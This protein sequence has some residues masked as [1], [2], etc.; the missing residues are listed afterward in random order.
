MQYWDEIHG[1][2]GMGMRVYVEKMWISFSQTVVCGRLQ[3]TKQNKK[4][5]DSSYLYTLLWDV[6]FLLLLSRG[7]LY[8]S[9]SFIWAGFVN[10]FNLQNT[11]EV[12]SMIFWHRLCSFHS[13][14]LGMLP[15]GCQGKEAQRSLFEDEPYVDRN[16]AKSWQHPPAMWVTE[17][18]LDCPAHWAKGQLQPHV[19]SRWKQWKNFPAESSTNC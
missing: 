16:A 7:R 3:K 15:Q 17:T 9:T 11:A 1:D 14:P 2:P 10:G 8:L 6:N 18:I 4:S 19:D 5:H 12:I 13:C